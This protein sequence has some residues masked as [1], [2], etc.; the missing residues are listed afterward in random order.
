M[1]ILLNILLASNNN[2][3]QNLLN[4]KMSATLKNIMKHMINIENV[5]TIIIL[6][7]LI[8]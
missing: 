2:K 8:D 1:C 7:E 4:N 3:L 6:L 5:A